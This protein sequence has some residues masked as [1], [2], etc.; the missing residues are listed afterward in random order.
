MDWMELSTDT[1]RLG[2]PLQGTLYYVDQFASSNR[3]LEKGKRTELERLSFAQYDS[4][5]KT[6]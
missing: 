6:Q 3:L 1:F 2:A 4:L 5:S